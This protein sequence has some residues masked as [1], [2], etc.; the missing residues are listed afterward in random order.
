[1]VRTCSVHVIVSRSLRDVSEYIEHTIITSKGIYSAQLEFNFITL[2]C[3]HP[4]KL[5]IVVQR[6]KKVAVNVVKRAN[7]IKWGKRGYSLVV[8]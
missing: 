3:H 1:M 5:C 7:V 8:G 4:I 2:S 6:K